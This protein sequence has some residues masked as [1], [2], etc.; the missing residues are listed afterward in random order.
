VRLL[1]RG[2]PVRAEVDAERI[3]LRSP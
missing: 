2:F 1:E 3:V